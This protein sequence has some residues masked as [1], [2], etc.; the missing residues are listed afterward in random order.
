MKQLTLEWGIQPP[1]LARAAWGARAIFKHGEIDLLWDRQDFQAISEEDKQDLL[2]WVN[3]TALPG[4]RKM[5]KDGYWSTSEF[6]VTGKGYVLKAD[7]KKS[8]GYLYIGAWKVD[9]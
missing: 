4:L 2:N 1:I 6:M 7:T 5:C 9:E 8:G 3:S